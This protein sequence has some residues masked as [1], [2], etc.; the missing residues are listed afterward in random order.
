MMIEVCA[1][2]R[3]AFYLDLH[4]PNLAEKVPRIMSMQYA[5]NRFLKDVEQETCFRSL[6]RLMSICAAKVV[7][8]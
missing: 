7:S 5:D 3:Q 6:H 2:C 1:Q 4:A 8:Q